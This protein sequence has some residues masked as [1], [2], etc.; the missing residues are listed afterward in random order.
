[1]TILW[2]IAT[3]AILEAIVLCIAVKMSEWAL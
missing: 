3:I 2:W 1:M